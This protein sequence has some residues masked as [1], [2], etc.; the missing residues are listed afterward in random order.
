[1]IIRD[2]V[3][4]LKSWYSREQ[5]KPLLIR[6]ARQVGKTTLVRMFSEMEHIQL[7]EINCE[8]PWQFIPLIEKLD[9]GT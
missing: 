8:K 3:E 6:G 7:V 1:M 9:P 5:R 4:A 2:A